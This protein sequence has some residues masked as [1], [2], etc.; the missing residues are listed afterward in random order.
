[1]KNTHCS[2][3]QP[4]QPRIKIVIKLYKILKARYYING[5]EYEKL[6]ILLSYL[7]FHIN[8]TY[9]HVYTQIVCENK[10]AP[11]YTPIV[12]SNMIST[13]DFTSHI[14]SS[15]WQNLKLRKINFVLYAPTAGTMLG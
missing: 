14:T 8:V 9:T 5:R 10:A 4:L 3:K 6:W 15:R 7:I 11:F 12:C 1:M 13:S 2:F